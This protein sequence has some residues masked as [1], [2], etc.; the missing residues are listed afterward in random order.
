[1]KKEIQLKL[2]NDI[3]KIIEWTRDQS[4]DNW[5]VDTKMVLNH[6]FHIHNFIKQDLSDCDP[7]GQPYSAE[8]KKHM[9]ME[10]EIKE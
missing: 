10:C 2:L 3:S 5:T 7:N 9:L 6:W 1:M 4:N 8:E